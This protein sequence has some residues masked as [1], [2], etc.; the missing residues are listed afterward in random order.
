MGRERL[1]E[2]RYPVFCLT[3]RREK[4]TLKA[5]IALGDE[6]GRGS[7]TSPCAL[8]GINLMVQQLLNML[9]G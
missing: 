8:T 4:F 1:S 5:L 7:E 9:N 6:E 3:P 2:E